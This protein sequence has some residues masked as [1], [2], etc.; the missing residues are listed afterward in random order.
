LAAIEASISFCRAIRAA[1][2]SPC[3]FDASVGQLDAASRGISHSSQ[4]LSSAAFRRLRNGSSVSCHR[5]DITSISA[6]LAIDF[7]VMCGTLSWTKPWRM[8]LLVGVSFGGV[9][10]ISASLR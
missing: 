5:S 3:S 1:H 7:R 4:D 10:V 8:S 6:L 9:A 2:H